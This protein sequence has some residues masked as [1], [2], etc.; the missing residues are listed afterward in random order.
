MY[1]GR[2]FPAHTKW[3]VCAQGFLTV[4]I[5]VPYGNIRLF[6]IDLPFDTHLTKQCQFFG[7]SGFLCCKLTIFSPWVCLQTKYLWY[8]KEVTLEL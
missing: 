4:K 7:D 3:L 2:K 1:L 6:I 5:C 8:R